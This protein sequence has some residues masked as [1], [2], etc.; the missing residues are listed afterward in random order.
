[1]VL[2]IYGDF[3]EPVTG[4][5]IIHFKLQSEDSALAVYEELINKSKDAFPSLKKWLDSYLMEKK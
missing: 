5:N 4:K 1:M 2:N 3:Q